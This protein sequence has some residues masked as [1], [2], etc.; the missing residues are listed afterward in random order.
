[1]TLKAKSE[2]PEPKLFCLCWFFFFQI[3]WK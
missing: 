2:T 1:M 3:Q